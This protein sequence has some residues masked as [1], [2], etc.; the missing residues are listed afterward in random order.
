LRAPEGRQGGGAKPFRI[1]FAFCGERNDAARGNFTKR[2]WLQAIAKPFDRR[3]VGGDQNRGCFE[4]EG[5]FA[6]DER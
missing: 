3:L 4:I 6:V 5:S 2:G 1:A